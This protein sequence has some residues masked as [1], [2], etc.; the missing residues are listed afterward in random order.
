MGLDSSS[1]SGSWPTA[2][3]AIIGIPKPLIP[4][5][6]SKPSSVILP[7]T[8]KITGSI[9][10]AILWIGGTLCLGVWAA[11]ACGERRGSAARWRTHL[12]DRI[13]RGE[14]PPP[15][16]PT[17]SL[18]TWRGLSP[19]CAQ[20]ADSRETPPAM[21]TTLVFHVADASLIAHSDIFWAHLSDSDA[22]IDEHC[23]RESS[24]ITIHTN[25]LILWLKKRFHPSLSWKFGVP[26]FVRNDSGV[27]LIGARDLI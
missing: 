16:T 4:A 3:E 9:R 24:Y 12:T 13:R 2:Q 7:Q 17:V 19:P 5:V 1:T 14:P 21:R 15:P 6:I 20:R 8:I 22:T 10:G 27:K 11:C 25:L 18:H 26:L 23:H